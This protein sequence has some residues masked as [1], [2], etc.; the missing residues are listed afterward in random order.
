MPVVGDL[1]AVLAR[2]R[3]VHGPLRDAISMLEQDGGCRDVIHPAGGS[4]SIIACEMRDCVPREP[5]RPAIR[6]SPQPTSWRS[7][8]PLCGGT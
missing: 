5:G 7:Q 2:L 1:A 3:R 6:R 8:F 4:F